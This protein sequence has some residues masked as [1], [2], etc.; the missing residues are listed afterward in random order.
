[1]LKSIIFD[2]LVASTSLLVIFTLLDIFLSDNQKHRLQIQALHLWSWLDDAKRRSLLRWLQDRS[3]LLTV[4]AVTLATP[5][6]VWVATNALRRSFDA[7]VITHSH[8]ASRDA[9]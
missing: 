5:Y 8:Y 2:G 7:G 9:R 3:R 1:M 4:I 6:A